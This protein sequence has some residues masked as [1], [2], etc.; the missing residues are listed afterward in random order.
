VKIATFNVN[1]IRMR[2]PIVLDWLQA[3]K[4]EVLCLQETK[5]QDSEFPK[6]AFAGTGYFVHFRGMKAY[7]GIAT[8]TRK[9]P[10]KVSFGLIEDDDPA[11][12]SAAGASYEKADESR[13]CHVAVDGIDILN[14]Y[15]PQGYMIDSPKYAFKLTWLR[16]L[17]RYFERYFRP[18]Q[19]VLW[20]GDMNVAPR[21]IDVHHPEKHLKHVCYHEAARQAFTETLAWGFEDLFIRLYPQRQQFT[22]WDYR[23][24]PG[25]RSSL[26]ANLGWRI[27]HILATRSLAERC[28]EVAVDIAPRKLRAASDHTFLYAQFT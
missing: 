26:E 5:V 4:P 11:P 3:A 20:C 12:V 1:S 25:G 6:E 18:D 15:V 27:D 21:P 13:V 2:L 28:T 16:R 23:V 14:T 8:L 10:S 22:F 17:R 7:N 19:P 9:E 24:R